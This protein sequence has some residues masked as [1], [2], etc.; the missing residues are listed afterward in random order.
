MIQ[1]NFYLPNRDMNKT[2]IDIKII[3]PFVVIRQHIPITRQ[4]IVIMLL[5]KL[6][7]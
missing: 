6:L 5:G 2:M 7:R 4:M 3:E 1:K